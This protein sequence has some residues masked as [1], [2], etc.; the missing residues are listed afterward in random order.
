MSI[1]HTAVPGTTI[2]AAW[3]AF[4]VSAIPLM[5]LQGVH[6][7]VLRAALPF[8]LIGRPRTFATGARA[9]GSGWGLIATALAAGAFWG[10]LAFAV[11]SFDIALIGSYARILGAVLGVVIP[12]AIVLGLISAL[13]RQFVRPR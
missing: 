12:A 9:V 3:F 7:V 13:Y 4:P 2:A 11:W 8:A 6:T 1:D 5:I 10:I